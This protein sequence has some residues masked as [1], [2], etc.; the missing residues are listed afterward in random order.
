MRKIL[1]GFLRILK[2]PWALLV[3]GVLLMVCSALTFVTSKFDSYRVFAV[4]C[5]FGI[6]FDCVLDAVFELTDRKKDK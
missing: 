1:T 5:V 3:Y 6:G 2:T 4:G